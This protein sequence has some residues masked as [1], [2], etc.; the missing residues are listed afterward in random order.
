MRLE[1]RSITDWDSFH[2]VSVRT[3]GFPAFHGRNLNAWIDCMTYLDDGMS[4]F[5]LATGD[6]LVITV[7]GWEDFAARI[8]EI[9]LALVD[10]IAI[11]NG[12]SREVGSRPMLVM[13]PI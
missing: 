12:R 3:F 4:R 11:C 9:A 10:V 5:H 8:P 2:D 13:L 6:E 1:T 7:S